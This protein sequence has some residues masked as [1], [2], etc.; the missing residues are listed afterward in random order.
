MR[1]WDLAL[2]YRTGFKGLNLLERVASPG[3][4]E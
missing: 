1:L 3:E 4:E 2:Q